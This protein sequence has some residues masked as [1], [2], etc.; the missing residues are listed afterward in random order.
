MNITAQRGW[1]I[2]RFNFLN[3]FFQATLKEEFYVEMPAMFSD[4]NTKS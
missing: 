3:D 2:Q 1:A 4:K